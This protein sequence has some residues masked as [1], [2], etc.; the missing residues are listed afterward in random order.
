MLKCVKQN[1]SMLRDD[2]QQRPL[3]KKLVKSSSPEKKKKNS[4]VKKCCPNS[5]EL[6]D[7]EASQGTAQLGEH[8]DTKERD[9]NTIQ[10]NNIGA[11]E[12]SKKA[13]I[14][15]FTPMVSSD[16]TVYDLEKEDKSK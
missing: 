7:N 16:S 1:T 12:R 15:T 2:G 11:S 4:C 9:N 3:L 8:T 6:K 13:K 10:D 5:E 14:V